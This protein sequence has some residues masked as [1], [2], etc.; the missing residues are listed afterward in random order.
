MKAKIFPTKTPHVAFGKT[1][2]EC[3]EIE[4]WSLFYVA[5]SKRRDGQKKS[6]VDFGWLENIKQFNS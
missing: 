3:V 6:E 4:S 1:V 2:S 5:F